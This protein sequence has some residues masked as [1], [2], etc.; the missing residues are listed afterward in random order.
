MRLSLRKQ[1][2]TLRDAPPRC[3]ERHLAVRAKPFHV[4]PAKVGIHLP[5]HV[6]KLRRGTE[7]RKQFCAAAGHEWRQHDRLSNQLPDESSER[8]FQ[9]PALRGI[10]G[11]FPWRLSVNVF[12]PT[13]NRSPHVLERALR[14]IRPHRGGATG[15]SRSFSSAAGTIAPQYFSTIAIVRLARLP[16]A[17]ARS[18]L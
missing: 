4:I 7:L 17:F 16:H 1:R 12:V 10:L 15:P 13:R 8:C 14:K 9:L 2:C 5:V 6:Q 3:V 11:K 18:E